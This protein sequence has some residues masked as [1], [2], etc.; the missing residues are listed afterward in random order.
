MKFRK[1]PL[2]IDA[3]LWDGSEKALAEVIGLRSQSHLEM[4]VPCR[5]VPIKIV[6]LEGTMAADIGDY[7]IKGVNGKLYPC[8]PDIF[9]KTYD[10]VNPGKDGAR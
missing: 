1:K 6:T 8:K 4:P 7:I 9:A 3:A 10:P 2:V 5:E